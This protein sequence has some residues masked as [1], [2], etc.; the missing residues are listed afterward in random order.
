MGRDDIMYA[1]A[2]IDLEKVASFGWQ[3]RMQRRGVKYGKFFS[4][5]SYGSREGSL[6]AAQQ[7]RDALV[8]ELASQT[9]VCTPSPRNRSGVVGV[10]KVS[11]IGANGNHYFFWQATWS[12]EPGRRRCVKFSIQ[13]YGD[14]EA[15]QLAVQARERGVQ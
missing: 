11:V 6:R 13:R 9:R 4:D 2:R 1:I 7:W 15:F 5:R 10:S 12:P 14:D 3:V 8:A